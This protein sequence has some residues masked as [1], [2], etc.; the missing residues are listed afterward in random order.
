MADNNK[1]TKHSQII[2]TQ[3]D[4]A[5]SDEMF[6]IKDDSN[7]GARQIKALNF[8]RRQPF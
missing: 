2:E 5:S 4:R 6:Q 3:F 7:G 1:L 8:Y